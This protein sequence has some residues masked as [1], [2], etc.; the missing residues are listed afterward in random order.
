MSQRG[1]T[2]MRNDGALQPTKMMPSF[3]YSCYHV[4]MDVFLEQD[5]RLDWN[6]MRG[7]QTIRQRAT[8]VR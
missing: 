1:V 4:L 5:G 2:T 7:L 3:V 8:D 6:V